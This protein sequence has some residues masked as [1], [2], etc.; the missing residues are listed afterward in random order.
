MAISSIAGLCREACDGEGWG[1][2]GRGGLGLL[3]IKAECRG[4]QKP[5]GTERIKPCLSPLPGYSLCIA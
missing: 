4:V 1:I 2:K 3:R 5:L